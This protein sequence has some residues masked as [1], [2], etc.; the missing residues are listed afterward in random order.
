LQ[1]LLEVAGIGQLRVPL[2]GVFH[3]SFLRSKINVDQAEA[4]AEAFGPLEIV[5]QAPVMV[6]A[7]VTT[8]D[9]GAA[10]FIEVAS[11][12]LN[13]AVVGDAAVFVR[14]IQVCASAFHTGPWAR[15]PSQNQ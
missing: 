1:P 7:H 2:A 4:L 5:H 10:Q 11:Q 15:L 13:A 8:V 9:H 12:E 3:G 6:S 14:S